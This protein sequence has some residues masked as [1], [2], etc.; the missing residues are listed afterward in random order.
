MRR[1]FYLLVFIT[2][3]LSAQN[4][5]LSL[6]TTTYHPTFY[7]KQYQLQRPDQ[8]GGEGW[9]LEQSS[10]LKHA[11]YSDMPGNHFYGAGS[12]SMRNDSIIFFIKNKSLKTKYG[13]KGQEAFKPFL[14]SWELRT[15]FTDK[16]DE[17]KRLALKN[18]LIILGSEGKPTA[19]ELHALLQMKLDKLKTESDPSSVKYF[20]D[21]NEAFIKECRNI[22]FEKKI[23]ASFETIG[24]S[25]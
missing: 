7:H 2:S 18:R 13:Y 3:Q 12:W 17:S 5:S 21:L 1:Y 9:K 16:D 24:D 15:D 20:F 10:K 25:Y 4:V 19:D 8:N 14:I 11:F 23:F 22:L 6:D